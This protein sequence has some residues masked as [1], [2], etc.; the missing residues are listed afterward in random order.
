MLGAYPHRFTNR[1]PLDHND[2]IFGFEWEDVSR[3]GA[4]LWL[5]YYCPRAPN[6]SAS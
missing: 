2:S 4:L 3:A 6:Y 5:Q 1:L